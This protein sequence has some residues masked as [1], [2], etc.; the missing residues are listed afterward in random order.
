MKMMV[1]HG[2]DARWQSYVFVNVRQK[3]SLDI[4]NGGSE[5]WMSG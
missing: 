3:S 4:R 5:T 2:Y 1:V